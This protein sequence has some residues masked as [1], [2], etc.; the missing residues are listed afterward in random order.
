V[1]TAL[2]ILGAS[3]G[4]RCR[5]TMDSRVRGNDEQGAV[6][7]SRLHKTPSSSAV[8]SKERFDDAP[9]A[10]VILGAS[11]G[12]RCRRTVDSR[13]RG[14]D[15]QGAVRRSRLHK[16]PSSSAVTNKERFGDAPTALVILGASRGSRCRRTM[17]SRVRGNDGQGAVRRSR[18]HKTP[19]SSAVMSKERFGDA[20]TTFI[21]LGRGE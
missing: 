14:N 1:P 6:R 13:V 18:L 7:R 8:M 5:S 2:V 9:T 16:T 17:D 20:P 12:S 10:L 3:R 11:R 21:I 15:G 4:S 19:S